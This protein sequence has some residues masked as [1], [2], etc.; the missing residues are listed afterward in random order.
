MLLVAAVAFA[1]AAAG[2]DVRATSAVQTTADEPHYLVTALSLAQDGDL[3]VRPQYRD[4]EYRPFY[5]ITLD[6]QAKPQAD[7]SLVEPHDPL[8]PVILA[9]PMAVGGWVLAKLTLCLIAAAVAA[10]TLW[11]AVRRFGVPLVPAATVVAILGASAPLAAYGSQV[12]PE[13]AGAL[14]ALAG[15]AALTGPLRRGGLVVLALAVVA[16][17]WLS[18]KYAPVAVALAAV[19]LWMLWRSGRPRVAVGLCAVLALAVVAFL[20]AHEALYGG[21]T[22]YA[23]G[24]Y[25]VDGQ[26]QVI[27]SHPDYFGRSRRL[28]GLFVDRDFGIAAWQPA[29]LLLIPAL[30][31][32][33]ALRPRGSAALVLPLAAGWFVATF[34][35]LTMQGWWF[36]GRQLVV[37]L[38]LAAILIAW[39]A[40]GGG[41][42][43]ITFAALGAVGVL[44]QAWVVVEGLR[45]DITWVVT[46]QQTANPLYR[47][48][49]EVLPSYLAENGAT[50]ILH[51]SWAAV[52]IVVAIASYRDARPRRVAAG[53]AREAEAA[54]M[55]A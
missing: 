26:L 22:P 39:W 1:T 47:A 45:G 36:P 32:L 55:T 37:V 44:A 48:W 30:G 5:E 7:G 33:A 38:P 23:S 6:P 34:V 4:Q 12:Y 29:W 18:V 2:V 24:S 9:V 25:F 53:P 27:G 20:L 52:A 28:V 14:A 15:V 46:L 13:I 11:T 50:W 21:T 19:G 10:L 31:A 35:A 17:P 42:R 51:W 8:L 49:R 40:R 41:W 3:D 16:L 43:L 54:K